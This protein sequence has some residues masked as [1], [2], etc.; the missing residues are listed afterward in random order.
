MRSAKSVRIR[1]KVDYG[2]G[3]DRGIS[4]RTDLAR[5]V[6]PVDLER[7]EAMSIDVVAA[8]SATSYRFWA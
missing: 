3:S 4:Q 6:E 5:T 7:S 1:A 8:S 2:V